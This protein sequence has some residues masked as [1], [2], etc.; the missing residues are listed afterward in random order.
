MLSL[1][2]SFFSRGINVP[3]IRDQGTTISWGHSQFLSTSRA[4][5]SETGCYTY[6][7]LVTYVT[8]MQSSD[9]AKISPR[10]NATPSGPSAVLGSHTAGAHGG[11]QSTP[12]CLQLPSS[13]PTC[14]HACRA[15]GAF[16]S[17]QLRAQR[18][19]SLQPRL[20]V[21]N[22]LGSLLETLSSQATPSLSSAREMESPWGCG[23]RNHL[24]LKMFQC[25]LSLRSQ[26]QGQMVPAL[27]PCPQ[28]T[29]SM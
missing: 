23:D 13:L 20:P 24:F 14:P 21:A 9:Q 17:T 8:A 11:L 29:E 3:G 18:L 5:I 6:S 15:R 28:W 22:F 2:V 26:F 7:L 16:I 12:V 10:T 25:H 1:P 19:F 4:E 27:L